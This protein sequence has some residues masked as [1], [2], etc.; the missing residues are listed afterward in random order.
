[1]PAQT[2]NRIDRDALALSTKINRAAKPVYVAVRPVPGAEINECF[3]NVQRYVTEH[4]GAVANGWAFWAWPKVYIE[5]EH[6]AV[7]QSPSGELIDI[8]P[9][10]DGET[11]ILFLPDQAQTY[12]HESHRRRDNIR[13][14]L[15]NDPDLLAFFRARAA[16]NRYVEEHSPGKTGLVSI[17]AAGYEALEK[18]ANHHLGILVRRY[19]K[20]NDLC[21]CGS[22]KKYKTCCLR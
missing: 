20:R 22:G 15:V 19:L 12:D 14:P 10:A 11:R 3:F 21:P 13:L 2:P 1:M 6:H 16:M 17:P 9:K 18:Q 4:G 7:W 5:A 8:T